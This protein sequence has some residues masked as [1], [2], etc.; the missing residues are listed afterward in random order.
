MKLE[1]ENSE[2]LLYAPQ[3]EEVEQFLRQTMSE[4]LNKSL[5]NE[6]MT[7]EINQLK[8]DKEASNAKIKGFEEEIKKAE[9]IIWLNKV[10]IKQAE[11]FNIWVDETIA[12]MNE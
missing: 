2:A 10:R 9:K 5:K 6:P 12:K 1:T 4:M 8:A 3:V 11:K 7:E